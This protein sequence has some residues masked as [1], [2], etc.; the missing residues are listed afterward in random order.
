MNKLFF[1]LV[2][3]QLILTSCE[4]KTSNTLTSLE[5]KTIYFTFAATNKYGVFINKDGYQFITPDAYYY[6]KHGDDKSIYLID[7]IETKS[8]FEKAGDVYVV[9]LTKKSSKG[10]LWKNGYI[11]KELPFNLTYSACIT[12]N[13]IYF[14]EY[15]NGDFY[16]KRY[17]LANNSI[18]NNYSKLLYKY[19][20]Y[21]KLSVNDIGN[22]FYVGS[23]LTLCKNGDTNELKESFGESRYTVHCNYIIDDIV[24]NLYHYYGNKNDETGNIFYIL[25]IYSTNTTNPTNYTNEFISTSILIDKY[26]IIDMFLK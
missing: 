14:I 13:Y 10:Y 4:D 23:G 3:I 1:L 25:R 26:Y 2:L 16:L 7:C 17:S 11:I 6:K 21:F 9:G 5:K 22:T 18:D 24:Y 12:Q 15:L 19:L 20:N 8:I